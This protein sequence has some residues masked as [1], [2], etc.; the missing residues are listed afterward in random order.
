MDIAKIRKK[1]KDREKGQKEGESPAA[2]PVGSG[3]EEAEA[4]HEEP[5]A[6]MEGTEA[7]PAAEQQTDEAPEVR[8]EASSRE[9]QS[10]GSGAGPGD[11]ER[12]PEGPQGISLTEKNESGEDGEKI[13]ELLTFSLSMEEFAFRVSEVEEIIRYQR[14]THVPTMPDYVRGITSLRGKIIPVIDLG[15]RLVIKDPVGEGPSKSDSDTDKTDTHEKIIILS[16]PKG[17]IGAMIDKVVGVVRFPEGEMLEPPAHLTE[18]ELQLIEGVVILEKRFISIIRPEEA[19]D[20]EV[21]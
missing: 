3:K 14:I 12:P 2:P 1:A 18:E 13:L 11:S 21:A 17:L 16:G 7:E 10:G 9:D 8:R 6:G 20:I 5:A 15:K 19:L 4:L